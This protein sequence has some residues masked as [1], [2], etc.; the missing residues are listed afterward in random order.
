[1]WKGENEAPLSLIE[2]E[3][4]HCPDRTGLCEATCGILVNER[5]LLCKS[6][7]FDEVSWLEP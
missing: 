3:R 1:M 5:L 7:K 4:H 6:L 2:I